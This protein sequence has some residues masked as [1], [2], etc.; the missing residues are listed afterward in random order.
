MTTAIYFGD[1]GGDLYEEMTEIRGKLMDRGIV[2]NILA[3]DLPPFRQRFDV[4]FFDWG[5][6]SMGNGLLGSYCRWIL[7]DA[8]MNPGRV[9]V[10][11]SQMTSAAMRD[12][13]SEMA[14]RTDNIY[15]DIEDESTLA[16]LR[17]FSEE[18]P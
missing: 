8:Y 5:G 18:T 16:A 10:M 3:T 17:V 9:Y 1:C 4:L 6:M 15:L 7:N 11:T 14:H 13:M 12:A 2:L